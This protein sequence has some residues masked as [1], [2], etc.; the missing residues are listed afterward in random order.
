MRIPFSKEIAMAYSK[1]EPLVK[2]FPKYK[3]EFQGLFEEAC[4]EKR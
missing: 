3:K 2:V 1:G 4:L